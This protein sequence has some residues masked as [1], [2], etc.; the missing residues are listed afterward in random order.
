MKRPLQM[1]FENGTNIFL[2]ENQFCMSLFRVIY[3]KNLIDLNISDN[4]I[5]SRL[6]V[7]PIDNG[8][9]SCQIPNDAIG[10]P[11]EQL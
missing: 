3:W 4:I 10:M 6:S 2:R 5:G 7:K 9:G 8:F 1:T 11:K